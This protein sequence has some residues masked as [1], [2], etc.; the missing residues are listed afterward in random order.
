MRD[1]EFRGKR[2]DTGEWIYG[3]VGKYKEGEWYVEIELS[4]NRLPV[5]KKTVGQYIGLKDINNK[6]IYKD[7]IVKAVSKDNIYKQGVIEYNSES[8]AFVLKNEKGL[9]Q[10]FGVTVFNFDMEVINNLH[11]NLE[12]VEE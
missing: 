11:D 1:I 6:K 4:G 12:I 5:Y 8:A 9:W 7:D 10:R 2:K 3:Y